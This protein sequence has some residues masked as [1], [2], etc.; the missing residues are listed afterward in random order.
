M[1]KKT[2]TGQLP[3]ALFPDQHGNMSKLETQFWQ[4]HQENPIVYNYLVQ[5]ACQWR[6]RRGEEAKLGIAALFERVRWEVNIESTYGDFKLNNNH[7]AYYAR[8]MMRN[9][10]NLQDIFRVRRQRI[11]STIGPAND[12]LPSGKHVA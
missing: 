6:L 5:F 10:P 2:W 8:L 4:F 9:N 1:V 3:L 11:Q 7:R 12:T